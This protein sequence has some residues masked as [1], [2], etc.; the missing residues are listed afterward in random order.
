M[1]MLKY[2]VCLEKGKEKIEKEEVM[3]CCQLQLA[4]WKLGETGS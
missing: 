3:S 4:F 2:G 1:L